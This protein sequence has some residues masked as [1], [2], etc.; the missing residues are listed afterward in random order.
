MALDGYMLGARWLHDGY[1]RYAQ[2][3]AANPWLNYCS[4]IHSM[5]EFGMCDRYFDLLDEGPMLPSEV[6]YFCELLLDVKLPSPVRSQVSTPRPLAY[7]AALPPLRWTVLTP[8]PL[9][10][11][12]ALP[13]LRWTVLLP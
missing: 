5:R 8:R 7:G 12:A 9:A 10:Y 3:E 1:A 11:G 2:V 4:S 13:P 6:H